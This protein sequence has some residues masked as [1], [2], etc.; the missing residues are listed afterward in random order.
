MATKQVYLTIEPESIYTSLLVVSITLA[1]T[2]SDFRIEFP[3]SFGVYDIESN[4]RSSLVTSS[5]STSVVLKPN[6]R[7]G[8]ERARIRL[9][10]G[11]S[12][13]GY[14]FFPLITTGLR[15]KFSVSECIAPKIGVRFP[16]DCGPYLAYCQI[17]VDGVAYNC[18]EESAE[19]GRGLK[20]HARGLEKVGD[21]LTAEVKEN[22]RPDA[23]V[24][25]S[26]YF[27]RRTIN[28]LGVLLIP[29]LV[30]IPL[31]IAW[32]YPGFDLVVRL[33]F[34]LSAIPALFGLWYRYAAGMKDPNSFYDLVW[35]LSALVWFAYIV[36]FELFGLPLWG[37]LLYFVWIITVMSPVFSYRHHPFQVNKPL[38]L[39]FHD[40]LYRLFYKATDRVSY[41][42]RFR[43]PAAR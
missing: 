13:S 35:F 6:G 4:A 16:F 30:G 24:D 34:T 37:S 18:T 14:A 10:G 39:R 3:S 11:V 33:S 42:G 21:S 32:G 2:D 26:M 36:A 1:E 40:R 27:R 19:A 15:L 31:I 29:L 9:S 12:D 38:V 23:P 7:R 17:E 8:V 25:V 28:A 20:Y 22:V 43:E 5:D 41:E